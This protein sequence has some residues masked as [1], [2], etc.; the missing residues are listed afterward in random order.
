MHLYLLTRGIKSEVDKFIT[1]LQ[2]RYLPYELKSENQ[3]KDMQ[4]NFMKPGQYNMQVAVRP[5]QLWEI[6]YP[7][8]MND[9][10]CSTIF[11]A[12]K[13]APQH[14]W[15][16]KIIGILRKMLGIE[17][18]EEYKDVPPFPIS[19]FHMECVAIGTKKDRYENGN[20]ML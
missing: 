18:L 17:K 2:G 13:G 8:P 20:E 16:N 14:G 19:K 5:I 1:E 15:Q 12:S 4:G 9:V 10:M 3:F 11:G 6:V 7:E